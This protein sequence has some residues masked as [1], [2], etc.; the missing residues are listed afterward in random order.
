LLPLLLLPS[1]L[2]L[3][4]L[5][6]SVNHHTS[7][8]SSCALHNLRC[9]QH[10]RGDRT[11]LLVQLQVVVPHLP[12]TLLPLYPLLLLLLNLL[13]LVVLSVHPLYALYAMVLDTEETARNAPCTRA[14][15]HCLRRLIYSKLSVDCV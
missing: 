1:W 7:I 11:L 8:W 3:V 5:L 14:T 9:L 4:L 2:L 12:R 6:F 10:R 13:L 15:L